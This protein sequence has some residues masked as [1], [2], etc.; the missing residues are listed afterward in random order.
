MSAKPEQPQQ[1]HPLRFLQSFRTSSLERDLIILFI[2]L[3]LLPA[4][5]FITLAWYIDMSLKV[6]LTLLLVGLVILVPYLMRVYRRV[7]QP[8]DNLSNI[9]EAMRLEDYGLSPKVIFEGG[10][11]ARL[12]TETAALV[13]VLQQHKA[14]YNQQ[15]YL[16]YR[17]LEQLALP[18]IVLDEDLRLTHGNRAFDLW[19]GQPWKTVKGLSSKKIGL[20]PDEQNGWQFVD[21]N[22]HQG[23]QIRYSGFTNEQHRHHL[24]ILNNINSEVRQ[25]QQ[26]AWQQIIRVLTHEIRNSLT[27]IAMMTDMMLEMPELD[28]KLQTPLQVIESRSSNLLQF[29]ERYADTAKPVQVNK[30]SIT[31]ENLVNGLLPLFPMDSIAVTG[32]TCQF[33]ADPV[34]L[35][36]VLINLLR[37][38]IEAQQDIGVDVPIQLSFEPTPSETRLYVKDCGRGIANPSNLFVPFYTTKKDGQGIGLALCRKIIEQHGGSIELLNR[39][40]GGAV[41]TIRLPTN[42]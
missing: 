28:P 22:A 30:Q 1:A 35:E 18:V 41:A 40:D 16:I 38:A 26:E 29:V 4:G 34:L 39:A 17:L 2:L 9:I 6:T 5:L 20:I 21:P 12:L 13:A 25:V 23:W 42:A 3:M 32:A 15:V 11:M 8:M 19:Y 31:S 7:T 14:R 33:S 10:V 24:L 36:Q 27:P 37:N